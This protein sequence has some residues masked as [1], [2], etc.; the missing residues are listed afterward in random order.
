MGDLKNMTDDLAG[1]AKEGLGK[2]SDD[3][4][5]EREGRKEQAKSDLQ[6]AAEKVK[7]AVK[8]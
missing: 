3:E 1:K 5:L 4:K 7:D 6:Q 8:H 2:V